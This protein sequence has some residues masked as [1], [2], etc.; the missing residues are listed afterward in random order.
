MKKST[1]KFNS[2]HDNTIVVFAF[3]YLKA[4]NSTTCEV[5]ASLIRFVITKLFTNKHT[6]FPFTFSGPHFFLLR[7]APILYKGSLILKA[8][9]IAYFLEDFLIF[10]DLK[11]FNFHWILAVF[12]LFPFRKN[13]LLFWPVHIKRL[14]NTERD[15]TWC[16]HQAFTCLLYVH[17]IAFRSLRDDL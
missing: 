7:Q 6:C 3:S 8:M 4:H 2:N 5:A 9:C 11:Q 17:T 14:S 16:R 10:I 12:L 15:F 1:F 13:F